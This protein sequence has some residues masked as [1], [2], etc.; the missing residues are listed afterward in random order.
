M[1]RLFTYAC[2]LVTGVVLS[3][4]GMPAPVVVPDPNQRPL[5]STCALS[6]PIYGTLSCPIRAIDRAADKSGS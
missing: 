3:K 1:I 6:C 4:L 5:S 2:S